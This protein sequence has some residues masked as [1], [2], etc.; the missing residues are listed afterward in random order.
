MTS[1]RSQRRAL[2]WRHN[3]DTPV[4]RIND[5]VRLIKGSIGDGGG[6]QPGRRYG[7]APRQLPHQR[8]Y[9]PKSI[10]KRM[11]VELAHVPAEMISPPEQPAEQPKRHTARDRFGRFVKR[12]VN[13]Q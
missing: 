4:G 1:L 5:T 11:A 2:P 9:G 7:P 3:D 13:D 12:L 8:S 10:R 6:K